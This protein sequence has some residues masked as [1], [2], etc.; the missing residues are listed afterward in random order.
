MW[1]NF[2]K[3]NQQKL[4]QLMFHVHREQTIGRKVAGWSA[5]PC[6]KS[7][8]LLSIIQIAPYDDEVENTEVN[9]SRTRKMKKSWLHWAAIGDNKLIKLMTLITKIKLGFQSNKNHS[10]YSHEDSTYQIQIELHDFTAWNSIADPSA[11]NLSHTESV[12]KCAQHTSLHFFVPIQSEFLFTLSF[13][14]A[15]K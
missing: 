2:P 14:C 3:W 5:M 8:L 6:P 1:L 9:P 11:E 4:N 12:I 15:V 10:Q 7:I 13:L